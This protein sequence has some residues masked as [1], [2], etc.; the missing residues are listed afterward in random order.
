MKVMI[1]TEKESEVKVALDARNMLVDWL[2]NQPVRCL[3]EVS[4]P[5]TGRA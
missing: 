3:T 5:G 2:F 1:T 4:G